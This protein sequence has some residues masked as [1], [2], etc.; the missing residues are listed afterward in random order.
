MADGNG[1]ERKSALLACLSAVQLEQAVVMMRENPVQLEKLDFDEILRPMAENLQRACQSGQS[2]EA[3]RWIRRMRAIRGF[4]HHGPDPMRMIAPVELQ[5]GYSGKILMVRISGG[6]VPD[7]TCLRSGDDWHREILKNTRQE[8]RDLGFTSC[9]VHELGGASA[10]FLPGMP[11]TVWGTSEEYGVCDK[12]A[13]SALISEA[14][15]GR[16]IIQAD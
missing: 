4:Q 7:M 5:E 15:P 9:S 12:S 13:V 8:I 6:V 1:L 3:G 16:A 2:G 14:F 10:F 11:I